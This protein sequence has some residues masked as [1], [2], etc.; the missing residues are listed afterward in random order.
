MGGRVEVNR[1]ILMVSDKDTNKEQI[2]LILEM[3]PSN[4]WIEVDNVSWSD[5]QFTVATGV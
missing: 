4:G 3:E 1:N 5:L 2:I